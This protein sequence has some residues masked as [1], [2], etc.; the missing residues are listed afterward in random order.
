VVVFIKGV[1]QRNMVLKDKFFNLS[2]LVRWNAAVQREANT[3]FELELALSIRCSNMD[4]GRFLPLVGVKVEPE[5]A[6]SQHGR[7]CEKIM[8]PLGRTQRRSLPSARTGSHPRA[9][10]EWG[11]EWEQLLNLHGLPKARVPI[12]C[13]TRHAPGIGCPVIGSYCIGG[14]SGGI[15]GA[16]S[17]GSGAG[18]DDSSGV[19]TSVS[20]ES[21]E[22]AVCVAIQL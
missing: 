12:N 21:L 4:M 16:G 14:G 6:D 5:T 18:G 17:S 1:P 11:G 2:N 7:H 3:W 19:E 13:H 9:V 10:G 15:C 20:D 22:S 8:P